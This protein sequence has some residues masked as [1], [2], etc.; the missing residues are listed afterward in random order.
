M[1][2]RRKLASEN[3]DAP[4]IVT[5]TV[6]LFESLFANHPGKVR[7][8]HRL[9][10]AVIVLDEVQTL[11]PELLAPTLDVLKLLT[12][13][14]ESGGYGATVVLCTATQP[15]F[16]DI[17]WLEAFQGIEIREIVPD[18]RRHF[19]ELEKLGRVAY[20]RRS[21]KMEWKELAEEICQHQART[22]SCRPQH[23]QKRLGFVGRTRQNPRCF[24]SL[25]LALR[26]SPAKHLGGN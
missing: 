10:R 4:L 24:S 8:L 12:T 21:K 13:P 17:H 7:K 26:C 1:D 6:Q 15:A 19:G 11:P 14:V 22:D 18:Y 23:A 2:F 5:T 9:A 3:W 25:Y 16:E 20:F